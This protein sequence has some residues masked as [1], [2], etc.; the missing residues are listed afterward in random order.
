MEIKIAAGVVTFNPDIDRLNKCIYLLQKQVDKI[1]IFDNSGIDLERLNT[2]YNVEYLMENKNL[3]IAHALNRIMEQAKKDGFQW[4][5]TMDQD[6]L[7]PNYMIE[8]F[9][10]AISTQVDIG[11][12]CPQ[13]ID[14]RRPYLV[15]KQNSHEEY[16]D[17]CITSASCTSIAA[18]EECGKFDEWMF[19][20]LVDND[21]C[22]R[23]RLSEYKILQINELI[24]DQ[25][26]GRVIP[27]K[28]SIQ[29]F[30]IRL[31]EI[32]RNQ[33][34]AKLSYKKLVS[35]LRVYYTNRNIIYLNKKMKLYGKV[36]YECYNCKGYLGFIIGFALPS[37]LRSHNKIETL[38]ATL[39]GIVDGVHSTPKV[40]TRI[41]TSTK[42]EEL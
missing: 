37:I 4:V 18:W 17:F 15:P 32:L 34:I 5:V 7:I 8:R 6:S 36:G 30:W 29:R 31:S 9:K 40:W 11:I 26:F 24:L 12:V 28:E 25:E 1:Y 23:L 42:E 33:N 13:V 3:G 41:D 21:F 22:K 19:I 16:I 27:K 20:D 14:K 38:R 35:P 10:K 39:C 2:T